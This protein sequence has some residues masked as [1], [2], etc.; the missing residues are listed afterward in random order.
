M[1][2]DVTHTTVVRTA[3]GDA[4]R[5]QVGATNS[6]LKLYSGTKPASA[7]AA[8]SSNTL[9]AIITGITLASAVSGVNTIT[10]STADPGAVGGIATFFRWT[11]SADLVCLQGTVGVSGSDLNLNNTTIDALATVTLTNGS[12]TA[13]P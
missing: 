2:N 5:T 13:A 9:I 12:Y 1:P 4:F 6:K 11:T 7:Q 10:A 8:L 3:L